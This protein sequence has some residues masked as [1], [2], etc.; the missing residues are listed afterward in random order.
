MKRLKTILLVASTLG[1]TSAGLQTSAAQGCATCGGWFYTAQQYLGNYSYNYTSRGPFAS[2]EDCNLARNADFGDGDAW[3]PSESLGNGC[4]WRFESDYGAY[5][6]IFDNYNLASAGGNGNG[7]INHGEVIGKLIS[8][9]ELISDITKLRDV[10]EIKSYET[11]LDSMITD[12]ELGL[13]K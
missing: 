1:L 11:K 8:D 9:K 6:E 13:R 12:P 4:S 2:E 10:Y 3:L 7:G 5:E